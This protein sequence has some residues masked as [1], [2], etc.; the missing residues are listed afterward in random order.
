MEI[1]PAR[2]TDPRVNRGAF[3]ALT[4][5]A[6]SGIPAMAAMPP[7]PANDPAIMTRQ[8]GVDRPGIV[9]PAYLAHPRSATNAT[10]CVL[11]VMHA[12]GVDESIREVVRR[13]AKS[14]IAAMA[15]NL[16]AR[17]NAP[18]GDGV[19]DFAEFRPFVERLSSATEQVDGDIRASAQWLKAAHPQAKI[20]VTGFC[21]G[22]AIALRQAVDNAD[23]FAADAVWYGNVK[24]IDPG[25]V[26]IPLLGSYGGRDT[27]IPERSVRE[28]AQDVQTP[29]DIVIYPQAGHAFFDDHRA[30][31]VPTAAED[32][33]HRTIAFFTKYLAA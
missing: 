33:W 27:G 28:F 17:E 1:D 24:G 19:S 20:G 21:M 18:D 9:M 13:F 15:P 11:V 12:W 8:V 10:P 16:Y 22:G 7:V 30:S 31:Y 23:V 32:A 14:G 25:K 26:R 3:V 2:S 29:H 4:A 5:A 6:L